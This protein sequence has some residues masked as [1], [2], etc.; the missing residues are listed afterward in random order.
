M[1]LVNYNYGYIE[2]MGC[3]MGGKIEMD[4]KEWRMAQVY[5]NHGSVNKKIARCMG[6]SKPCTRI[7]I[8]RR[9]DKCIKTKKTNIFCLGVSATR[10]I[11]DR[12][13]LDGYKPNN[14]FIQVNI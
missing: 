9:L 8:K 6:L 14:Y 2:K 3:C 5:L 11:V 7:A 4:E 10:A 1:K 13:A 12:F